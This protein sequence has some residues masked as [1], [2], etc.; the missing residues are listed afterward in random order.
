MTIVGHAKA[1]T[2]LRVSIMLVV[3]VPGAATTSWLDGFMVGEF[4]K[5]LLGHTIVL[6]AFW[7]L[8]M[9]WTVSF[10]T[11]R[12]SLLALSLGISDFILYCLLSQL[13]GHGIRHV[14]LFHSSFSNRRPARGSARA[15]LPLKKIAFAKRKT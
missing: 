4:S 8:S 6:V 5:A 7:A 9:I 10:I 3:V 14:P 1:A 13:S 15:F 11:L 12:L 2:F